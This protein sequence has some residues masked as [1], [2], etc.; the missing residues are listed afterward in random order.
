MARRKAG[1]G[2]RAGGQVVII[3]QLRVGDVPN[4]LQ[5]LADAGSGRYEFAR[6]RSDEADGRR[7][8]RRRHEFRRGFLFPL[9][10]CIIKTP[11]GEG[12]ESGRRNF[13]GKKKH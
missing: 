5:A 4:D 12:D 7:S 8:R 13:I 11:E 2:T 3:S 10:D 9:R 1:G 6:Q